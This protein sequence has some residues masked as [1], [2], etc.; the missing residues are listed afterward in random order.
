MSK[1]LIGSIIFLVIFTLFVVSFFGDQGWLA[2][3]KNHQ[4]VNKISREIKTSH[5]KI[6]SLKIEEFK[7]KNDT[8]YLER[9]AREKL[10][11]ARRDEKVY[12]FVEERD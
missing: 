12:K 1:K 5:E 9:I 4:Q 6:D 7:L 8:V 2:L 3:Y 11:M 10:G